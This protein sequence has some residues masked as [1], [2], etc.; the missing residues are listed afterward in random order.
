MDRLRNFI[1]S[2]S[3]RNK[4]VLVIWL[5]T[6]FVMGLGI[7]VMIV[8]E[9][10]DSR[11]EME[12][13]TIMNTKLIGEYCVVPMDFDDSQAA[14]ETLSRLELT[15]EV[16][17]AVLYDTT[18]M[19]FARYAAGETEIEEPE[20][21]AEYYSTFERK[22]LKV[23]EPIV[24][25]GLT[26]GSILVVSS[27]DSLKRRIWK[28]N[29]FLGGLMI[30]MIGLGYLLASRLQGLVSRPIVKLAE[31]TRQISTQ[32]DF[33][34]RVEKIG[35]DE[36]GTLYDGFNE[37]LSQ[38]QDRDNELQDNQVHLEEQIEA[39]K[40]NEQKIRKLNE[41]LEDRVKE[42]TAELERLSL[43]IE[44][45]PISI[46]IMDN[47]QVIEYVNP[48][49]TE[50]T[51]IAKEDIIGKGTSALRTND[52][53]NEHFS[54]LW[55]VLRSGKTWEGEVVNYT[56]TGDKYWGRTSISPI[57]VGDLEITHYVSMSMD[58]TELKIMHAE[59]QR[60]TSE[61]EA[62]NLAKSQFLARMSHEI[63]TP[64]NAIIGLSHI[65]LKTEL[66][67]KQ[68][69]FLGKIQSSS[70]SL[71]GIINDI[72]DFSK[73][74]AGKLA[75]EHID[76]NLEKVFNNLADIVGIKAQ[77]KNLELIFAINPSIPRY[78]VGDPLRLQQI[79]I[80]LANNA[81]KFSEDGE[82]TVGAEIKEETEDGLLLQFSI[83]DTGI[84]MT[85]EQVNKLFE[86]F[87]Q[88]DTSTTRKYGGTGL[89]LAISKR[90]T[91]MMH[92]KIW[93]E[94]EEGKGSEFFFTLK[95]G[96]V[97]KEKRREL[98]PS[99]D[100]RGLRVLVCD[101][102]QSA[103]DML[104]IALTS[105]TFNVSTVN[106]GDELLELLKNEDTEPFELLIIDWMMPGIDGIETLKT[107]RSEKS[108]FS[109]KT[110]LIS[111]YAQEELYEKAGP[112]NFDSILLKPVN[113]SE[114]FNT[115]MEV[116][117]KSEF[118]IQN[119]DLEQ[120][121]YMVALGS[122]QGAKILL[123][124]DNKTNQLVATEL[125][126]DA[127]FIIEVATNGEEA[128][129]MVK[130]SGV[131][132]KYDLVL[133]DL[134]M[135]IMD[136]YK[137]TETIRLMKE[138]NDLPILA[139]TADVVTGVKEKCLSIGMM[140]FV[141]KPII[142]DQLFNALIK[143]IKPGDREVVIKL[144]EDKEG[145][146]IELPEFKQ[147]NKEEGLRRVGGN[148]RLFK[149]LLVRFRDRGEAP[150]HDILN[151]WPE[152]DMEVAIRLAHTLRGESGNI[153][154]VDLF[155]ASADLEDALRNPKDHDVKEKFRITDE[156]MKKVLDEINLKIPVE[157][158][159]AGSKKF[160]EIK[161]D[162]EKLLLLLEDS[163]PQAQNL[164]AEMSDLDGHEEVFQNI[165]D[166]IDE[167]EFD[168]AL[169]LLKELIALQ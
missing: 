9:I 101:D 163:N 83:K 137:A 6:L 95:V 112:A 121:D 42:R 117:S 132:S 54:D 23:H 123:T 119:P 41:E 7:T 13:N 17:L 52:F 158:V 8:Q 40:T 120:P 58:I 144:E 153:G 99:P 145:K 154:M 14:E 78:L 105:F 140:D 84:G 165:R 33:S 141:M 59:L 68:S 111:A 93:V 109:A 22:Y 71:L 131:P 151:E 45:A 104:N 46:L 124:E 57:R 82:I 66:N 115:I 73:I 110:I 21:H 34:L 20:Y 15:P 76:F 62:A 135:P 61:A 113:N 129:N 155:Q 77:E 37:M 69:N 49:F 48:K 3:I 56:I 89:G 96:K 150:I 136:G 47:H 152:G 5:S 94:S 18:G 122:I 134:Q 98:I 31:F 139:M 116:F 79:L 169:S 118:K 75:I 72:L 1:S 92:G 28:N 130:N 100:L 86:A 108:E 133:M 168:D 138:Y 44:Q 67:P 149:E 91:E 26:R 29:L 30:L 114:L 19:V 63:R 146:Y 157:K 16:V 161:D 10:V 80:N 127:G 38:I 51:G 74:E 85:Q 125:L 126:K 90:L 65:I 50:I 164:I 12:Q 43:A 87:V 27:T 64:M 147:I 24:Y 166:K 2:L 106:S 4:L 159:E 36:I 143:W 167:F 81:L 60:A 25:D 97:D 39:R 128:V 102:S 142:P 32:H 103:R 55:D 88:A 156:E 35:E 107:I 11:N 53:D 162:L 148:A 160:E 70:I